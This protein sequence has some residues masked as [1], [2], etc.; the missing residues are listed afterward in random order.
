VSTTSKTWPSRQD[1]RRLVALHLAGR[2]GPPELRRLRPLLARSRP[3]PGPFLPARPGLL[4]LPRLAPAR[5]GKPRLRSS[6]RPI[7]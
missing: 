3:G 6:R 5:A 2:L 1:W 7:S 4:L